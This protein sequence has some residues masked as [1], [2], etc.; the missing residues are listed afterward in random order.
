MSP[1]SRH[2]PAVLAAAVV[3]FLGGCSSG[4]SGTTAS[5]AT[6]A[7]TS[8]AAVATT[9]AAGA[10]TSASAETSASADD[11]SSTADASSTAGT[12][13]SKV[14]AEPTECASIAQKYGSISSA[15]LPVLQG[16]TGS[17]P[18]DADQLMTAVDA[19]TMG[20][21]PAQLNPDF[22]AFKTAAG[23][24]RGKDLTA[25]ATVLN[26]PDI[27]KATSDIEKFLSDHC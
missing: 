12:P 6:A 7:A 11:T 3:V 8:S 26:G 10:N 19:D 24:L 23:Q 15:M 27:T 2:L 21:I 5:A 18:F 14:F 16:Q 17:T 9:S 4:G 25:A 20:T 1:R 22:A 13:G